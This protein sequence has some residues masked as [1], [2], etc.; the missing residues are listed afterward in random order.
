MT[1][2]ADDT[3]KQISC[4]LNKEAFYSDLKRE[5]SRIKRYG[6]RASFMLIKLHISDKITKDY[7]AFL[8]KKINKQ[9]RGCDSVY[10]FD[11]GIF[12]VILPDTHEGGGECAALRLKRKLSQ[13]KMPSGTRIASSIGLVSAGAESRLLDAN[14][15]LNALKRDLT[16][17]NTCQTLLKQDA[18]P[19]PAREAQLLLIP[20]NIEGLEVIRERL[21]PFCRITGLDFKSEEEAIGS[22]TTCCVIVFDEDTEIHVNTI[23]NR[24]KNH[25]LKKIIKIFVGGEDPVSTRC[26]LVLPG[27]CDSQFLSYSILKAFTSLSGNTREKV[28][29]RKKYTKTL[30]AISAATH[31]LNQPLQIMLGKMELMLLDLDKGNLKPDEVKKMVEQIRKQVLLSADINQK[32]NR[33]TKI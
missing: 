30:S 14:S 29:V 31:Q 17:D 4:F 2:L 18:S 16:R 3:S 32:I 26:D 20:E 7:E 19:A 25:G 27:K 8:Y 12:A 24:L 22:R 9:L 15:I 6:H 5:L 28:D 21:E 11:A 23:E 1:K 13:I 10:L 33:L